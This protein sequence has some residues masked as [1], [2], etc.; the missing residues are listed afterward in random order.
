MDLTITDVR[1]YPAYIPTELDVGPVHAKASLSCVIVE[2]RTADGVTGY[3]Y[4]AITDE[5]V[6]ATIVDTLLSDKLRGMSALDREKIAE[7]IYWTVSPRGQT[8][9][10]S[11]AASAIDLALWDILGKATGLPC[12]QLLG[13]AR[14]EV[15]LYVTFGFGQFD[16]EQLADAAKYLVQ[17]GVSRLKMVVGHHAL[18]RQSEGENLADILAEDVAR[19]TAVREAIGDDA[20]IFVDANCNLDPASALWLAERL[21]PVGIDFFEEPVR[22]NDVR[23]MAEIRSRG[24]RVAAG[25]NEGQLFRFRDLIEGGA[26]DVIQPNAVICGGFTVAQKVAALAEAHQVTLANGGAFPFHN[27]HLHGGLMNGG[28]VEWHLISVEMGNAVFRNL[29]E[30]N[31]QTL[32]L[33]DQPGLGFD[34]DQDAL[35]HFAAG[36]HSRGRGKG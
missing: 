36:P 5:E 7:A 14:R 30:R 25:Q 31:G 28:L 26:V 29:P 19:V 2:V 23:Q 35:E 15:P 32:R 10:G 13:G 12:W 17:D 6:I 21:R 3:G 34:V 24:T 4:T 20:S 16:R 8:G 33:P 1:A 22:G 9:Y 27:M 18:R 11:H